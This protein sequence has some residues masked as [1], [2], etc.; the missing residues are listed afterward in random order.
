M[1]KTNY[2]P[3][4]SSDEIKTFSKNFVVPSLKV[5]EG[6]KYLIENIKN[7]KVLEWHREKIIN[8]INDAIRIWGIKWQKKDL[9]MKKLIT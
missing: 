6:K 1:V 4:K 2:K 8:F 7:C 3:L 9:I 5:I